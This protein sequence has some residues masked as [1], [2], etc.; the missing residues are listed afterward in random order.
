[1]KMHDPLHPGEV[2]R[3]VCLEPL[4]LSVTEA[5]AGLGVSRKALSELLNGHAG[6]SPEM[7]IRL[8][9][10]FGSTAEH[11]LAMQMQFDLWQAERR[12]NKIKV[13][14]FAAPEAA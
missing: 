9:K 10:A 5:A 3:E 4:D 7:A 1:M 11:W 12:A 13:K 14:K 8:A 6:V 2:I